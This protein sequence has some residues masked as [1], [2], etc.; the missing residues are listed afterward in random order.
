MTVSIRVGDAREVLAGME[1]GSVHC[2]VTS[3]PYWSLRAYLGGEGMIGMEPTWEEHLDNLLAVFRQVWRV[4]RDD[5]VLIVNYGDAYSSGNV[6]GGL[7]PKNL[8]M[9]PSRFAIAMQEDG[10]TLRSMIPLLKLNPM[11]ESV[12]DRPTNAVEYF[13]LF[14]KRANYFWDAVAVRTP[15]SEASVARLS[16]PSFD[17][18]QGG[19]KDSKT[20]NRSHRKTLEN[21]KR[22]TDKQRGH[23]RRHDGFNDRWDAMSKEEQQAGGANMRN[24]IISSTKPFKGWTG[25]YRLVHVASDGASGDTMRIT[26][27]DCPHHA[28]HPDRVPNAFCGE[29]V[30]DETSRILD[31]HGRPFRV[32]RSGLVPIDQ[33]SEHWTAAENSD[34]WSLTCVP[35]A[36]PHS[37]A[38]HRMDR[39]QQT[40]SACSASGESHDRTGGKSESPASFAPHGYTPDS[41]NELGGSGEHPSGQTADRTADI[42]SCSCSHY[43]IHTESVS[44]F[45]TFNPEWIEPF[46][47]AG[48][49]AK[50]CCPECGAPWTRKVKKSVS[51][52]S[53]SGRSGNPISGKWGDTEQT[54][55]GTYDIRRGPVMS[56]KTLRWEPSC[57]CKAGKPVPCTILDPFG[58]AGTTALVAD[59]HQRDAVLIEIS[60]EY[61]ELARQRIYGDAPLLTEV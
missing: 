60:E 22:R 10:W 11:P 51:F 30:A 52:E 3:P 6:S 54:T 24:Y 37:T 17:Q 32:Q 42:S 26:S 33:R 43:E 49:S 61:A 34:F 1:A 44:H 46:I 57:E 38:S 39:A 12:T 28:D 25:T 36:T 41:R 50:G 47:L 7:P 4:M 18:Q 8:M 2:V 58:G 5:A 19:P 9:M 23:G 59:R 27:Q 14:S 48:T 40:N 13:F 35:T 31:T 21:L 45:A 55:S 15:M 29:R 56:Q 16:Q 53:G 20:G